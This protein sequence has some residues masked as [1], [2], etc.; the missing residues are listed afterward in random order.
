ML[1]ARFKELVL[2]AIEDTTP[3]AGQT[4]STGS[5]LAT[6]GQTATEWL[7]DLEDVVRQALTAEEEQ[8][9]GFDDLDD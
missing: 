1:H 8:A 5:E 2:K 4:D 3:V 9:E 6:E 7:N